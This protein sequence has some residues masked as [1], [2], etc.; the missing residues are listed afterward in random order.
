MKTKTNYS[1][2]ERRITQWGG[3]SPKDRFIE[4]TGIND[5]KVL[6]DTSAIR[7]ITTLRTEDKDHNN[8]PLTVLYIHGVEH[9]QAFYETPQEIL[10]QL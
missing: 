10:E 3:H 2:I 5:Q 9:P 1:D 6:V 7:I 8:Q 4:L